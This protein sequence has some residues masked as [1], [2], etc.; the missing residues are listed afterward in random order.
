M[1]WFLFFIFIN[2]CSC[3][4]NNKEW[5]EYDWDTAHWKEPDKQI[6]PGTTPITKSDTAVSHNDI[7]WSSENRSGYYKGN[8]PEKIDYPEPSFTDTVSMLGRFL[9]KNLDRR[10]IIFLN[11]ETLYQSSY[12]DQKKKIWIDTLKNEGVTIISIYK[13]E[14]KRSQ[15]IYING[16]LVQDYKDVGID[17]LKQDILSL[18][19][20]SFRRFLF[21]GKEY[22][23]LQAGIAD[24]GG[25]GCVASYHLLYDKQN[26]ELNE[27]FSLRVDQQYFFGD[28]NGDNNLDFLEIYN[29]AGY[30]I[31]NINHFRMTISSATKKG[32]FEQFKDKDGKEYYISGNSG[33]DYYVGAQMYID[34]YYWPVKIKQ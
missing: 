9:C 32:M 13:F 30:G 1:K 22:Y 14:E 33:E 26:K 23:Y 31:G 20:N 15:K 19:G 25:S 12:I 11:K 29:D 10:D 24:C 2:L 21:H 6:I 8:P 27:F 18:S 5:P 34:K 16:T 4:G 28:I 3:H 17:T 7:P